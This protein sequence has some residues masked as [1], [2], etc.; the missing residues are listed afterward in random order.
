MANPYSA[1]G[2]GTHFEASVVASALAAVLCEGSIRGLVGHYAIEVRTQ[3]ASFDEPL[4]DLI[5][6]GLGDQGVR[7]KL[8]LQ[9][10]KKLTFTKAD[11]EW[12]DVLRRAWD[13][14]SAAGFDATIHRVGVGIGTYTARVDQHYQTV[15]TWAA[16]SVDGDHFFERIQKKDFS[17]E[18]KR[19]FVEAVTTLLAAHTARPLTNDELRGFLKSFVIIYFDFQSGENSRDAAN[20]ID[21]LSG[22]LPPPDRHEAPRIWDHLAQKSATL[23]PVGGGASRG[24]LLDGLKTEGLPTGAAPSFWSDIETLK[25]ES[26]RTLA[27][28]R[29][30]IA[31]LKLHRAVPYQ[32]TAQALEDGRFVQIV[33][34]PGTGKSAILKE[35]AEECARVGP[36]FVLK[37][38]RIHPRGW[39]AHAHTLNVSDDIATLLR[40][41]A[42]CGIPI[43]FV[44]GIDK[45]V[46]PATQ[47][48]VNDVLRAIA[49]SDSLSNWRVLVT[50]REQN[51]K[52]LDTWLDQ[53]VLKKLPLRNVSVG[54]LREQ[55][56]SVVAA[57]IPRLGPLLSQ[58][59]GMDVVL[60]RP[61][62]L[63][64]IVRLAGDSGNT[65]L[66]ATEVE[67]LH[68]WW[69]LGASERSDAVPAQKRRNVLIDLA[70]QLARS[71]GAAMAIRDLQ[72]EPLV[73][74]KAAG[75]LRDK[76]LGHSVVFSHDIYEEW[77][78]C[79]LLISEQAHLARVLTE[80]G[81]P[82]ALVR[83]VQLLGT[84]A[85]E[86]DASADAWKALLKET[87]EASLRPVWQRA[88]LTSCFQSTRTTEL[89]GR[90]TDELLREDGAPLRRLLLAIATI[91]VI[92]NARYLDEKLLPDVEPSER[93]RLAHTMA[94]PKPIVWVR[95]LDWLV[96]RLGELPPKLVPD[97]VPVF[98]AWQSAYSGRNIRHCRAIGIFSHR[99]LVEIEEALHPKTWKDRRHPF[100][101]DVRH[102]DEEGIE[103][104]LR[105]LF[106][107][108]AGDVPELVTTYLRAKAGD[109][110]QRH[111]F[112]EDIVQNSGALVRHLPAELVD[113]I[114]TAFVERPHDHRDAWG[115]Y[116]HHLIDEVGIAGHDQFYPASPVQMPFLALL[117]NNEEQGLRLIR[118]LCNHSISIWRWSRKQPS[119]HAAATP[120]PVRV[121]LPWGRQSF[122]G[123]GQV[124][125][126]FRG[127]QGN[128]AVGSALMALE[129]WALER[130]EQGAEFGEIFRNVVEGNK[131][132]AA[133]GL[134][135]SLCLAH[136]DKSMRCSLPLVTSAH[137]WMWDIARRFQ[138]IGGLPPNEM[139]DWHRYRFEL[140][141]VRALN[142]KPHRQQ[143]IRALVLAFVLTDDKALRRKYVRALRRFP[144]LLPFVFEEEKAHPEHIAELRER[145]TFFAEQGDPR[146]V[147]VA[148]TPGRTHFQVWIEPP[149]LQKPKYQA[150]QQ[151][152]AELN[153]YSGL[154]LWS[155]KSL[156][157]G[158]LHE[159]LSVEQAMVKGRAFD[160]EGLFDAVHGPERLL[161]SQRATAVAGAA[162]VAAR[163]C[164]DGTW[165]DGIG[166]WCLDVFGRA[167]TAPE[168]ADG[169]SSRGVMLSM[170]P[171]VFA[172]YGY[173]GLLA[174]GY[175][176]RHCKMAILNLA[177]DA[178]DGVVGAAF[179]SAKYYAAEQPQFYWTLLD[180]GLRQCV[181]PRDAIP[182]Y[183]SPHWD[184]QEAEHKLALLER[185]G[186]LLDADAKTDLPDMPMPWIRS[187]AAPSDHHRETN[188]YLRNDAQFMFNLAETIL[189]GA[190][191]PPILSDVEKRAQFLK[192]V[193]QLVDWTIQEIVP[194][195]ADSRR[196]YR[197][198]NTPFG[199]VF[200]FS[201]WCGKVCAHL[202]GEE[203]RTV[204]LQR[205]LAQ[206][207]E[208]ALRIMQ[209][210]MR[211]F[212]VNAFLVPTSISDDH[213][214]V[215]EE[216]TEWLFE[217]R[218]WKHG[219][220]AE[221]LDREFQNCALSLLFCAAPDFSPLICGVD[222]GWPQLPK[223]LAIVERA[224]REFGMNQQLYFAVMMFLK[225]GGFDLLPDPAL[226]WLHDIAGAKKRDQA[227]WN[228]NGDS[229]VEILKAVSEQKDPLLTPEHRRMITLISDILVD[230]GVRGAGFFQ[231]ELL[232]PS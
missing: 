30:T 82:Q 77:A 202:T 108:S 76:E 19:A 24:T 183:H 168:E 3:R 47:L 178:L 130:I 171:I 210:L 135:V 94:L 132:V 153:E 142:K 29:S 217:N 156:E 69:T 78:L 136:P 180:L 46:D 179:A 222:P 199:W 44:D 224:I 97:L 38:G 12:A 223:F 204:I 121:S 93:A 55:E 83:P 22:F 68:L 230:N 219:K 105:S 59:G 164:E 88:V 27:D 49:G 201:A 151:E 102:R 123:D 26:Q 163:Y 159:Q 101:L 75:V 215:W 41:F 208:T 193:G 127:Y 189:F 128:E 140:E 174:R 190:S 143:D 54:A 137:V 70:R 37:D 4:D 95:F 71:P 120:I 134:G 188:G 17:H 56:L 114:L 147:K 20:V 160:A 96:P 185:A 232:R 122:W 150:Q 106:L 23:V 92:P 196:R 110:H 79:E 213:L 57:E 109:K 52:H 192:L 198:G 67:L 112:R 138:D 2:G 50:V 216:V 5:V 177:V 225:R 61:F 205:V 65:E 148:P 90:L 206:D 119:H 33:G 167:A 113:F 86:T 25:R 13:T 211:T 1:G 144:K 81:E 10:K 80:V 194:P 129:H 74:L 35:V 131:C 53:D 170:N 21:R 145:M 18:D 146:N 62:F 91:E 154:A 34:E 99:W 125:L 158:K 58:P 162:F 39:S 107:S 31:D 43:L 42:C 139:G 186:N 48:T 63:D 104:A 227:F 226:G 16:E 87:G 229:T 89:L 126:W 32:E 195:F 141:A 207:S 149:S 184:E 11:A 118:G 197:S 220:T 60:N 200:G 64:A 14:F 15:L 6:T 165:S 191:L 218:E 214:V 117:R 40:E 155:W 157:D 187:A 152:H 28:I 9:I 203:C 45:I 98:A 84:Y 66:P 124:Y 116:D 175:E 228:L 212:M 51:L 133:L 72:A 111:V 103:K 221:Y 8:H 161:E 166:K 169:M 173:A 100:G 85:L 231:Q 181:V 209:S 7:T 172:A 115:S 36:V 182:K 176:P 73:E